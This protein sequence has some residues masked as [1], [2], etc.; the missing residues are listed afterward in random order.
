[1]EEDSNHHQASSEESV[2][3]HQRHNNDD[4]DE[5]HG[6]PPP[7]QQQRNNNEDAQGPQP[8]PQQ[9]QAHGEERPPPRRNDRNEEEIFGKLKFTMPKFQGEEDPDAYLSWVLKV[10]KIFRIHNFSEAKKVWWEEVN[11]KREKEDLAP[12]DTWEEMKE[13]MHTRFVPTHH[14]RDLFNKLTQLKQSYKSVEEYYKEM[15]MTMMSANVDERE[16]QTMARFLN[17]LNIPV[18]RIVEFLP[19]KNMVELLHQATRAERQVREDLASAKT[20]TFFAARNAMNASSSIKNTSTLASKDPPKQARSAIKTTSF[21]PEQSTMSSKASTGSSNITCFKCGAQGH[22]SFECKNTRVMITRDDGDVEYL[23]EGEYEALVQAA[24]SHEDDALED[25]EQVLCVHDASPSLV[26]TKVL[27]THALPNEDQ[28]CNIFQTRAGINGKSIKVIIDGGSCHNLASTELCTK[29]NLPLRKHPH[30]YHV[31]WL[32]DN[33]NVKIQHTVTISFKIGAYEDTVD[34]DVVPMTVCHMLLGRPW[35]YDKKANHDGYTNAYSFKVNDKTYILRPMTPSQVIADNAKALAR[36]KEATITSELRGERVIHQKESERHKPYVSEMKS[37]LL[38]TKSEMREV[39]HNPSTTLHYVLICKGPSEETNDLTNIPSSLLSILK[40]F[41]DVFPDELPHGL[42]PLR[43]IEHRI[44]LIP[45]APLPNRAAYRTNP[46]DTKEIQR[47]IQD[48][49]AKGNDGPSMD[50]EDKHWSMITHGGDGSKH[51]RIEDDATSTE[52]ANVDPDKMTNAEMHAHF[53][54]LLGGHA[55]DVDG[56]LGDV[57]AKLTDALDKIDGLEAAFNSKL[58]AKFQELLTRLPPPRANVQRRARRVPRADVPAGTAPAAA[59]AHDAPSDEGYEDYGGNE[60]EQVDEN[61]LDDEEVQQPAPGRPRQLNRHARPPPR[62]DRQPPWRKANVSAGRTSSWTPRQSAPPSRGAASAPSTSKY[63]APASRAPPAAT[64]PPSAGPPR[65]SSSMASTGK[66]RDIQC[67][68]CLGFGHIER[69]CRTKRVMLVRE[70]GEYDSASDFDEDTLALIAARDGANS[71]S[72]REMEVMEADTADQYRSLVAQRVLSVQLSKAEHD[73]RH[74]LFQTRGV[75]KERAI[76]IIIDGGSCNNLA[77]VDMVEKLSLPTRQRTH[78][79]YIQWF[80]SSRKLKGIEVDPA[81]IEAI[82]NWPQPKTVTQVRSFLGLAGFYRRFVK[83]F[84]SIAA[85]L[86]E[87]TKK[88]VPFVWGDAQQ[89]AFMILKDKLT[90]APLLQLPDFNK[91]FELECDASGIGLGGADV[92]KDQERRNPHGAWKKEEEEGKKR[93]RKMKKRR[94]EQAAQSRGRSD[95]ATDRTGRRRARYC[96]ANMYSDEEDT[97][98]YTEH[99]EEDASSSTADVEEHV[100]LYT[101][102]GSASIIGMTDIEELY[103]DYGSAS[104]A[105][106]DDMVEHHHE[107]DIDELYIDNGS[108]SMDVMV[109]QRHDYDID[110]M[111]EP[112]LD[113][114]LNTADAPTYPYLANGATYEDR[115]PPRWHHHIIDITDIIWSIKSAPNMSHHLGKARTVI[116]SHHLMIVVDH[117]HL[118]VYIDILPHMIFDDTTQDMVMRQEDESLDMKTFLIRRLLPLAPPPQWPLPRHMP[119][120]SD[121]T[122][123][124]NKA[125]FHGNVPISY[126]SAKKLYFDELNAQV[127]KMPPLED[128]LGGDGVEHG[129]HGI[130]PSP[131]EAHGVE[132]VEHGMFPSTKEAHGDEQV[133]PT[134]TCLIDELVPTPC[135]HESHL[136]HLSESDS[137]LS[138]FHPICEFECFHLEDMSDT[139]SSTEDEFPLMEKMYMVHEDDDISPCLLQDGHVDHMDPPTSTTPTSNE[140]A[141]K[142]AD[143]DKDQ[144]RRNPHGAW[145]KEEEEGKKR[146]RKMKKRREEQA[147]QS[148]GRSDRATDRTGRRRARE[149]QGAEERKPHGSWKKKGRREKGE[150]FPASHDKAAAPPLAGKVAALRTANSKTP[151]RPALPPKQ[152]RHCRPNRHC[153]PEHA[154]TAGPIEVNFISAVYLS[155][156]P[157]TTLLIF[158]PPVVKIDEQFVL[159]LLARHCRPCFGGTSVPAG[160]AGAPSAALPLRRL[161]APIPGQASS[162]SRSHAAAATTRRSQHQRGRPNRRHQRAPL[163]RANLQRARLALAP[164][165]LHRAHTTP[166]SLAAAGHPQ[167][168]RTHTRAAR[169]QASALQARAQQATTAPSTLPAPRARLRASSCTKPLN[170]RAAQPQIPASISHLPFVQVS[171]LSGTAEFKRHCRRPHPGTAGHITADTEDYTEHFEEDTSS[172]TADVEEHVELYTDYG[173]ASIANMTDI[174]ELYTDYGSASIANMDDMVEHHLEDDI[175]E[176]Y[177]D[178]GSSS[179]DVMVEHRHDYDIDTM[180]EPHLDSTLN[181]AEAPTYPYL[182]NGATYEDRGPPRWHHHIKDIIWSIKS[183][184]NMI[185]IDTLLQAPLG[186]ASNMPSRMS[187]HLGMARTVIDSH[188]LMIVVDHHHLMVYIDIRPHMIFDDTTQDMVMRHEDESLDMKTFLIRR[189]LSLVPPPQWPLP[190]H[191]P[192]DSDATSASNKATLHGNVP[193]SYVSAKKLYFDELNAQVSKMPPL[194]DDLG[195]DGVEHGEHGILPSPTEA[196]GVEMVEHGM[197]PST[198][199]AHG[200]EQV[201]PTPICLI[202]EL[203]PIPCEHESHLAHLSES[204]SEL[205]DFHPICEFECFHLEDMSVTQSSTEDEF[206]LMETMYMVHEDD[207]IS[208]CLL[209]D[210]HVD[211]MDPPTSTTPTSHE[212]AFKVD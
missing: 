143:V 109:E 98:E 181:N 67:R 177:I 187:H 110:N 142:G 5:G 112:H 116:D 158:G 28:R 85:P 46:E 150:G 57:D 208:P 75:V 212:S 92:D 70:D 129:E 172:S 201:E 14:K 156:M 179:M 164:P 147:A 162:T 7:P 13:V 188:H 3:P 131:T 93:R 82:E 71:D 170:S 207:D 100:E 169:Q 136:A 119:M 22:K 32:S 204:D 24:T 130:L 114:T 206:P 2:R 10:D 171:E 175:D 35:Q 80:E 101:D 111:A 60:D 9:R 83:D 44:D 41:Q 74:N 194:E 106:M 81:K 65:S 27:T 78:P 195:G 53:L 167:L 30:P 163:P 47:Q 77:S 160:T 87:L 103:T 123:A 6:R 193:I 17:G 209:Q 66:T 11:K 76:R 89:D 139:Q 58:D 1:M 115:G 180:A 8:Q 104:I 38:A 146:R 210:G 48:L 33:G 56:R 73:Q 122:S 124:S 140:S 18:K 198:K 205:S 25:Q 91:T 137:E 90:H 37:V 34:C 79:Y 120:D 176:L 168:A 63:T 128:D 155:S 29:L 132:M 88:D 43:G 94:E 55:T 202:D 165:D 31:Q 72:E 39:H 54:H 149:R 141:Y 61:M 20:K 153:R 16:E 173:S 62:P 99:F 126:V 121:A 185:A 154:G 118:M 182:A 86:N 96:L 36:A 4:Q 183:V 19:Y 184:P 161:A 50:E 40:E 105:D 59:A 151:R 97:E 148:R 12:I 189:L 23:S 191:M 152:A 68:K 113:S 200:D 42:P 117:H 69:E 95:R 211:H 127:S 21:K 138:D 45:G 174:E 145:K 26:V 190:R 157:R 102:Y 166:R 52:S 192:M 203:V 144:E 133:E 125:T 178:N 15:H 197:F 186:A 135:E 84:G 196:H 51:L 49:L 107:D 64:P 108:S 159:F 134:P 199:E